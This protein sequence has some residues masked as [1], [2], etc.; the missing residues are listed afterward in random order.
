LIFSQPLVKIEEDG[1]IIGI[2]TETN[3][4]VVIDPPAPNL[5]SDDIKTIKTTSY[6]HYYNIDK[7]MMSN[8]KV[9][10][11][12]L[13]TIHNIKLETSFYKQFRDILR[14]NIHDM[15][16][17]EYARQLES[18]SNST[19]YVYSIKMMKI[20]ELIEILIDANINFVEFNEDVLLTLNNNNE[21][22]NN[23]TVCIVNENQL[24]VPSKN[25]ITQ[26]DN[27][28]LYYR[29]ISDEII[30]FSRIKQY[31]F[32]SAY[33]KLENINYH[34][35][36]NEVLLLGSNLSNDYFDNIS[37]DT[38]N[39][40]IENVPYDFSNPNDKP[41]IMKK[42]SLTQQN[43]GDMIESFDT[44]CI[45]KS[46]NMNMK[47]NWNN[48]FNENHKIIEI[49]NTPQ[50]SY[51]ILAYLLKKYKNIEENLIQIKQRLI[52][53][54]ETLLKNFLN[55]P[56]I[57]V[58]LAKQ[59]K[60]NF[61]EKIRKHQLN[62]E[63]MIMNDNYI[64][65][66]FDIWIFCNHM[67]IPAILYSNKI[68]T[69]MKLTTN[70]IIMG[71]EMEKDEYTFIHS[72]PYKTTDEFSTPV[73]IVEPPMLLKDTKDIVLVKESLTDYLKNYKLTGNLRIKK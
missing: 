34:I 56:S 62:I 45:L 41:D 53:A 37:Y 65:T 42:I 25:L 51:Y 35:Q 68:Y 26:E 44:K 23:H 33:T 69:S 1:L 11:N 71:G 57:H 21:I 59:F 22:H 66:Q 10:T 24:C 6:K 27:R 3:Q 40:Y 30:R 29:R 19:E 15:M 52:N 55:M 14:N 50:C 2:L 32:N 12:R 48:I 64:I 36:P 73:S 20:K 5:E 63:T 39:K 46:S 67:N 4:L 9:D 31:L 43:R 13:E 54:Y 16:N 70:Y 28:D 7:S 61:I 72:N 49:K 8:N 58:I 60:K 47:Q 18:L 17:S 38:D